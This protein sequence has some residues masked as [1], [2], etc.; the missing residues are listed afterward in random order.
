MDSHQNPNSEELLSNRKVKV[1]IVDTVDGSISVAEIS[2]PISKVQPTAS[3]RL[4]W[5]GM[6]LWKATVHI[7]VHPKWLLEWVLVV[8]VL[9]ILLTKGLD[10]VKDVIKT[11]ME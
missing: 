6:L 8:L 1:Q 7:V 10:G 11:L 9:Q 3:T 2:L 4:K 5:F